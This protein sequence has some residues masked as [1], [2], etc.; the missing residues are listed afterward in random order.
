MLDIKML[1]AM[2]METIFAMGI[3]KNARL[4]KEPVKWV[5]I[6]GRIPDWAIY[7]HK[8]HLDIGIV[9]KEGDKCFTEEV[10]KELVP[11]TKEAFNV[12]RF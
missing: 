2:P 6:R 9:S 1:E 11:C 10:I 7:Y 4:Y 5:A 8:A 12:Y 3:V